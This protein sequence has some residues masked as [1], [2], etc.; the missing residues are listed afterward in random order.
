M[1]VT[2]PTVAA[3]FGVSLVHLIVVLEED[4]FKF[5]GVVETMDEEPARRL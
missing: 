1:P 2:Y 3:D 4:D 5:V